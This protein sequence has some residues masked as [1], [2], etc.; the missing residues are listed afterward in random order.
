MLF[1]SIQEQLN[2]LG[3][4]GALSELGVMPPLGAEGEVPPPTAGADIMDINTEK[5]MELRK[6]VRQFVQNNP[7]VAAV[8][9]KS[10]IRG[11]DDDNG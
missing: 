9:L 11:G 2:E 5:S 3:A 1:R 4:S 8:M 6:A 10:W 7:E